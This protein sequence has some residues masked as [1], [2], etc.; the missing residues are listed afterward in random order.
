MT[1][2]RMSDKMT[3]TLELIRQR[4]ISAGPYTVDCY[5]EDIDSRT[6]RGLISRGLLEK[7][8]VEPGPDARWCLFVVKS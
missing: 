4:E 8:R 3:R 7:R 5:D 6:V 2:K 1:P